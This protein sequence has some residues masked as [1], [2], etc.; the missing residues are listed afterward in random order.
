M[1]KFYILNRLLKHFIRMLSSWRRNTIFW[2]ISPTLQR[3]LVLLQVPTPTTSWRFALR[4]WKKQFQKPLYRGGAKES[5]QLGKEFIKFSLGYLI[6]FKWIACSFDRTEYFCIPALKGWTILL[7][8]KWW[9]CT[10]VFYSRTRT[11]VL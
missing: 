11:P 10:P 5:Q 3:R 1:N 2:D 8:I 4:L 7:Y 9:N 6:V